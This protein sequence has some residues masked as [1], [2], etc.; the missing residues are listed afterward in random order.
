[1]SDDKKQISINDLLRLINSKMHEGTCP[2][3]GSLGEC[4]IISQDDVGLWQAVLYIWDASFH[5]STH[6]AQWFHD[7]GATEVFVTHVLYDSV[8]DDRNG[9]CI[10]GG[11]AWWVHFRMIDT[12]AQEPVKRQAA[13]VMYDEVMYAFKDSCNHTHQ[14]IDYYKALIDVAAN[15]VQ[16]PRQEAASKPAPMDKWHFPTPKTASKS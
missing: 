3:A 15:K 1:M 6:V 16:Q 12:Q 8:N 13:Q 5:D 9:Q 7:A 14:A 4:A 10:D 11:R 2:T